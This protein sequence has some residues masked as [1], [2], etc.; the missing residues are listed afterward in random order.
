[1][2]SCLEDGEVVHMAVNA[3]LYPL[4]A[5]EGKHVVTVEGN[6]CVGFCGFH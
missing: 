6:G 5:A 3:C 2:I 4:Y 1:M